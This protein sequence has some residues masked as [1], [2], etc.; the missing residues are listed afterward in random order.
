MPEDDPSPNPDASPPLPVIDPNDTRP[1]LIVAPELRGQRDIVVVRQP[2][3]TDQDYEQRC[4][5]MALILDHE[6]NP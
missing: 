4:E 5:P 2:D 3:D 1:V 6:D